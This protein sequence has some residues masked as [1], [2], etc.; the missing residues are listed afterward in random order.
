MMLG[1]V[2]LDEKNRVYLFTSELDLACAFAKSL[3]EQGHISRVEFFTDAL[4][5]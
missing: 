5:K 4:I 1:F 2:V 3:K